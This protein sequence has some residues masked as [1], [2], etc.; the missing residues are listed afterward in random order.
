M[1]RNALGPDRTADGQRRTGVLTE[2]AA[3]A[4]GLA[5]GARHVL[6]RH[7]A[8]A[9][10]L[11][12]AG[13]RTVYGILFLMS[14]LLYRNYFYHS[15]ANNAL[16]HFTLVIAAAALGY[17]AAAVITPIANARLSRG[18]LIALLLVIAGVVAGPL[19]STFSQV[20]FL[21]ISFVVAIAAQGV[22]ISATTIIQQEVDDD[23][24]GRV[25]AFY[26]MLFNAPFVVGA[27]AGAAFMPVTGKS[28]PL[29]AVAG[30]GYVLAA[31]IYSLL[32][33]Q[34]S[35]GGSASPAE[36]T[37]SPSASAQRRSS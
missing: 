10:L 35:G 34:R 31:L 14:I 19:G 15:S 21:V 3:V 18:T 32:I 4:V 24:R 28:Y 22:A 33:R 26:D 8:A 9:A 27:A 20:P 37:A 29:L 13:Q 23:F 5:E 36:G 11:A 17:G 25:F 30:G 6:G 1:H 12:T 2:L 7:R 16:A